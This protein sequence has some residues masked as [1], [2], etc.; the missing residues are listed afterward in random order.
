[1]AEHPIGGPGGVTCAVITGGHAFDVPHFHQLFRSLDG[2]DAY[3]QTLEDWVADCAGVRETYDVVLFYNMH[4][5]TPAEDEKHWGKRCRD[6]LE[7]LGRTG[8]GV[9]VLHHGILAWPEWDVWAEMVG[10]P[11]R[12]FETYHHGQTVPVH[13]EDAGHPVTEGLA[14]WTMV[15]ETYEMADAGEGCHVLLTTDHPKSARTLAWTRSHGKARVFCLES[16]HDNET[17][18]DPNF[19]RVLQRGVQWCAG[20]L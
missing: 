7:S 4:R 18:V 17:W 5:E 20:R 16:G 6:A 8:Q 3:V 2:I 10:I 1:M 19:R 14:D 9:L 15:D 13:V 12:R 11:E